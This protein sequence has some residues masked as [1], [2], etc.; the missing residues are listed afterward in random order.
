M[1]IGPGGAVAGEMLSAKADLSGLSRIV[2]CAQR[3]F[4]CQSV[5]A[6]QLG[7]SSLLCLI[8]VHFVRSYPPARSASPPSCSLALVLPHEVCPSCCSP[9][10]A[11]SLLLSPLL[12]LY[13]R[14]SLSEEFFCL[15]IREYFFLHVN[16]KQIINS[17]LARTHDRKKHT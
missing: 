17:S 15:K 10:A 14:Y 13:H 1:L 11:G 9:V 16:E 8:F 4:L 12:L 5:S 3:V 2:Y 7:E 6:H